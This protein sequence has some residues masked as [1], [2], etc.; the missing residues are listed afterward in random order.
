MSQIKKNHQQ[1]S[2]VVLTEFLAES[3]TMC[4]ASINLVELLQN[5][6]DFPTSEDNGLE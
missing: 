5:C 4:Y 2:G 1:V 3:I 6:S